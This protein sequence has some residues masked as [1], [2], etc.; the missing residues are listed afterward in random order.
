MSAIPFD[1]HIE[2]ESARFRA[3]LVLAHPDTPV[4]TCPDWRAADLLWHLTE[5][6]HFWGSIVSGR[7]SSPDGVVQPE[8]P[9]SET[10]LLARFDE[11]HALLMDSLHTAADELA[12]WTWA[13]HARHVGFVRR[14][15]A[16]EALIH[17]LDAEATIDD[18]TAVD[19]A[20]AADGVSESLTFM[21][22][23]VPPWGEPSGVGASGR[24]HAD[25][26]GDEWFIRLRTW[27]GTSPTTGTDYDGEP[28]LEVLE[29]GDVDFEVTGRAAD[30][31]AWLWNRPPSAPVV[32]RGD[33]SEID[34]LVAIGVD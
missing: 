14:R 29:L 24:I 26:T 28:T 15:Q 9:G 22:G 11:A 19:P 6:Q 32:R 5:V 3:A 21:L 2:E 13:E 30:L 4:P 20:F 16:H 25:D 27:S 7:A 1:A 18:P 23:G 17:R 33:T 34:A 12:V 8:R 31:D 10:E